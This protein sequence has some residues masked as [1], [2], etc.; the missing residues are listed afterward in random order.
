MEAAL[1]IERQRILA[2]RG[3][4]NDPD[5]RKVV[6]ELLSERL[7]LAYLWSYAKHRGRDRAVER[8]RTA[9]L[10]TAHT[11]GQIPDGSSFLSWLFFELR[12]AGG[13]AGSRISSSGC[14]EPWRITAL[15]ERALPSKDL[16]QHI[17]HCGACRHLL[18]DYRFFLSDAHDPALVERSSW[19]RAVEDLERFLEGYFGDAPH[20]EITG[21]RSLRDRLPLLRLSGSRLIAAG[22]VTIAATG[23]L[24]MLTQNLRQRD[25]LA[26]RPRDGSTL[27]QV[28]KVAPPI[29]PRLEHMDGVSA[30]RNGEQLIFSWREFTGADRYR[31]TFFSAKLDTLH[32]SAPLRATD[33][34]VPVAQLREF[35]PGASYL[36]KIEAMRGTEPLGTSG[37]VPF[38]Q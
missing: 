25:H 11:L 27:K 5:R 31:V 26:Q 36:Y 38:G 13:P 28:T 1:Q 30:S 2:A 21:K 4:E 33:Y 24:L 19:P 32:R 23:V 3:W 8:T 10:R 29:G 22:V 20:A 9:L 35:V 6:R 16:D 17:D 15:A 14:P 7:R 34:Q 18:D 12:R 37:F